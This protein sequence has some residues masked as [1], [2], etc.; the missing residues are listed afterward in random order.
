MSDSRVSLYNQFI[1]EMR[2][3]QL[4]MR[5]GSVSY[6]KGVSMARQIY[7]VYSRR[8]GTCYT[9]AKIERYLAVRFPETLE[10]R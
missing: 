3:I 2:K 1:R 7:V 4:M 6:M 8:L 10:V 5:N 9:L